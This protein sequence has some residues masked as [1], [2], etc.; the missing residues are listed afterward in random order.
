MVGPWE[1]MDAAIDLRVRVPGAL[2]AELPDG[3]AGTVL[4]VEEPNEGI[5]GVA[6][7]AFWVRR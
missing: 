7:G 2:G 5:S 1:M 3:P 4:G 6:V